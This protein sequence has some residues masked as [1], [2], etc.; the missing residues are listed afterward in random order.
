MLPHA[1]GLNKRASLLFR[2]LACVAPCK[3]P[4]PKSFV[5]VSIA[6]LCCSTQGAWKKSCVVAG[7]GS[8]SCWH[9]HCTVK[10]MSNQNCP[11]ARNAYIVS[12]LCPFSL[13]ATASSQAIQTRSTSRS[14][15]QMTATRGRGCIW[16]AER[17]QN[18]S[19]LHYERLAAKTTQTCWLP[20]AP[21]ARL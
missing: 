7:R 11:R 2:L 21:G 13:W 9:W 18:R 12:A 4:E 3:G 16:W 6:R 14:G 5:V 8:A 10:L 1:G 19:P 15:R 17:M 20:R